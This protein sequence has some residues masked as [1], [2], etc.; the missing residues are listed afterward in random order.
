MGIAVPVRT[1]LTTEVVMNTPWPM[2]GYVHVL[3]GE[4]QALRE[5]IEV[6]EAK[7]SADSTNSNKPPSSD[8]PFTKGKEANKSNRKDRKKRKGF[9]QQALSPTQ[10]TELYPG[11]CSCGC[12]SLTGVEPS[13]E[14]DRRHAA[15]SGWRWPR[16]VAGRLGARRPRPWRAGL[17]GRGPGR[18]ASS[19][20][21][22]AATW[23][24]M[25]WL[26][27]P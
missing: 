5:R 22:S 27:R 21:G 6:L 15:R 1:C 8:N 3:H 9:R 12:N 14:A 19:E 20:P 7:L 13:R 25:S 10:V 17:W 11:K 18:Y 2:L 24:R 23:P 16:Q 26:S 4:I